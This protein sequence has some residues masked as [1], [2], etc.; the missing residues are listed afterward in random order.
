LTA[1]QSAIRIKLKAWTQDARDLWEERAAIIEY[2]GGE[3]R[4][5]AEWMALQDI[6]T[7]LSRG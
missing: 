3:T 1:R 6:T 2:D 7:V 4:D 5:N